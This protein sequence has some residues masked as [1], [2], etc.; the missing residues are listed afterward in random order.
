MKTKIEAKEVT[1][2]DLFGPEF[3]FNI[4]IYQ[5]NLS[6]SSEDFDLLF[7]DIYDAMNDGQNEYFLGS[8]LLQDNGGEN[9]YEIVDGQQRLTSLAMLLAVLRDCSEEKE[10]IG[11]YLYQK[12]DKFKKIPAKERITPWTDLSNI[13]H[14]YIYTINGTELFLEDF[15]NNKISYKDTQDPIYHIYEGIKTFKS[16]LDDLEDP[17]DYMIYLLNQVYLVYIITNSFESAYRLFNV[18]NARGVP[19]STYDLLKSENLGA[20]NDITKRENEAISLRNIENT[21]GLKEL[22]KVIGFI[23]TIKTEEKAKINIYEEYRSLFDKGVLE[24]G[25]SFIKYLS[26][27][28]SIY[29]KKILEPQ[30]SIN[31]PTEKN[32]YKTIIDLMVRFIPN[33]D[34][35]PPLIAFYDKFQEEKYLL[36]FTLLLEKKVLVEWMAGFSPTE[37]IT[38][39]NKIIKLIHVSDTPDDVIERLLYY[40]P[41]DITRGRARVLDFD[42]REEIESIVLNKLNDN[43]LYSI[44]GGKLAR[45]ILLRLDMELWDLAAFQGYNGM[46]TVEHILPQNPDKSSSWARLFNEDEK[47]SLTNTLGNLVLLSGRKNSQARNF[48]FKKKKEVYFAKKSTAFQITK[49]IDEFETW[50]PENLR[51]RHESLMKD[52]IKIIF[53][54]N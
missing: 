15:N 52:F 5:R 33:S 28:S 42:K 14:D 23:R 27:I 43:Q 22:D 19:L 32:N 45:Y 29:Q 6:W 50:T 36:N 53:D 12:E 41:K 4:P 3:L 54:T 13:F 11:E 21:I 47:D 17:E 26:V 44:Y 16:K 40:K 30:L 25:S 2:G 38:S 8:I 10:S 24:R 1:V 31:N 9:L 18:L 37:R 48:D 49:K 35:I 46:I 39:L 7:E 51:S 20:I 34:W